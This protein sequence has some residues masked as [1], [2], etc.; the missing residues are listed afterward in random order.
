[1]NHFMGAFENP[2]RFSSIF[3]VARIASVYLK[4]EIVELMNKQFKVRTCCRGLVP[5]IYITKKDE[6]KIL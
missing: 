4:S 2:W 5:G 6:C 3:M 1:M